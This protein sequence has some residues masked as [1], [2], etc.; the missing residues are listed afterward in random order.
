[1][2][3]NRWHMSKRSESILLKTYKKSDI[4]EL[5]DPKNSTLYDS[6]A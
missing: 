2:E 1:M 3:K 5:L 4:K 6:D